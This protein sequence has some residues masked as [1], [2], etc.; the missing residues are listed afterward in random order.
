MV[1]LVILTLLKRHSSNRQHI[2]LQVVSPHLLQEVQFQLLNWFKL[3]IPENILEINLKHV[4]QIRFVGTGKGKAGHIRSQIWLLI[5][6]K[7]SLLKHLQG[8]RQFKT[9]AILG[10]KF[11]GRI[12]L[13]FIR[14]GRSVKGY[15]YLIY[16]IRRWVMEKFASGFVNA[17]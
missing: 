3:G 4:K 8:I 13:A 15:G 16:Q 1:D 17:L 9:I 14:N 12:S 6:I 7:T 5:A 10:D 11:E 2:F